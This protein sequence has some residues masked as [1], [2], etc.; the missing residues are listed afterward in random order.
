VPA[1]TTS[2]PRLRCERSSDR[3]RRSTPQLSHRSRLAIVNS[4]ST[5]ANVSTVADNK[6]ERR[7]GTSTRQIV[8]IQPAPRERAASTKSHVERARPNRAT[9]RRRHGE[10]DVHQREQIGDALS[11]REPP[12]R[13]EN[14]HDG[15]D[16]DRQDRH[17]L[18]EPAKTRHLHVHVDHRG[19]IKNNT[20]AR[21][22]NAS[23]IERKNAAARPGWLGIAAMATA[24][25]IR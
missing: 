10:H 2:P 16:D 11:Q 1:T 4:P 23:R 9:G 20:I 3:S 6:A 17:H 5:S 22:T 8:E 18:H 21:V 25:T 12:P 7:L 14:K 24:R 19:T 15:R 13:P